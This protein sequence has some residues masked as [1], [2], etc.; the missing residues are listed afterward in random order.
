M[1]LDAYVVEMTAE[2]QGRPEV[3]EA[4]QVRRALASG[5]FQWTDDSMDTLKPNF[6]GD[7]LCA[8]T[9]SLKSPW[10]PAAQDSWGG[11]FMVSRTV[12]MAVI[13]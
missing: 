9:L 6:E 4:M 1:V 8:K 10:E 13:I 11:G 2:S 5:T 12:V 3:Q 7:E